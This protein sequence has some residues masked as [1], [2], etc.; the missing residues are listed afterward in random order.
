[1]ERK[2]VDFALKYDLKTW[3][4]PLL[5]QIQELLNCC[6]FWFSTGKINKIEISPGKVEKRKYLELRRS[7]LFWEMLPRCGLFIYCTV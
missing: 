6:S 5:L 4:F 3:R 2:I 1:M 7:V